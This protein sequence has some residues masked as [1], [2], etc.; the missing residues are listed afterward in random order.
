[1]KK[2]IFICFICLLFC[3]CTTRLTKEEKQFFIYDDMKEKLVNQ[4]QF[5]ETMDCQVS[6]VY[7]ELNDGYRYDIIIYQPLKDMYYI[8]A[9]CYAEESL[10]QMCP[11]IGIFDDENYHLKKD[12]VNKKEGFYKGIQL[13]G[14]VKMKRKIKLYISYYTDIKRTKKIEKYIEV[15]EN[16]I[17]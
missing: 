9:M 4:I 17:R 12:Y 2:N 11:N 5:D 6:L 8:N 3:G 7:N 14:I 16:E 13:S 10:N 15:L 1:M